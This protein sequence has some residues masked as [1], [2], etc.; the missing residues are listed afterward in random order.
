MVRKNNALLAAGFGTTHLDALE[1]SIVPVEQDLAAAF[2]G[3]GF[4]RAFTSPTVRRR[5]GERGVAVE[6]ADAALARLAEEGV[7]RCVVQPTLVIPGEEY[8]RLREAVEHMEGRM[9]IALGEPLLRREA[10]WPELA[11][12]L[13]REYPIAEDTALVAVGHGAGR[14]SNGLY[15]A[16]AEGLARQEGPVLRLATVEGTPSF[17]DV[18]SELE[19][20]PMRRALLVPLMLAAGDHVKNDMAGPGPESLRSLLEAAGFAVDCALRGLGE[21]PQIRAMYVRRALTAGEGLA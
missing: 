13:R 18:V 12:V 19:K 9:R 21:L 15:Q 5:L 10:D 14:R 1:K 8:D 20:L 2:P 7:E 11:R 3:W 4:A 16:M 6:S 17:A